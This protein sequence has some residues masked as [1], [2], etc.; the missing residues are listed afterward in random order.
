M[1]VEEHEASLAALIA[2]LALALDQVPARAAKPVFAA[3]SEAEVEQ[4]IRDHIGLAL[5][6]FA[7]AG[8]AARGA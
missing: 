6:A 4:L 7:Q 2:A 8:T 3:W 1:T 5:V